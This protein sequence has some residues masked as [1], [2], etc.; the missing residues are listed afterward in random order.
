M[1]TKRPYELG[2]SAMFYRKRLMPHCLICNQPAEETHHI[3]P[4]AL[5]GADAYSNYVSLC[6]KCHADIEE[7]MQK[8]G[9]VELV[10]EL[11]QRK[12]K[13]EM[14]RWGWTC[15]GLGNQDVGVLLA[16]SSGIDVLGRYQEKQLRRR[17]YKR[18]RKNKL[19]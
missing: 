18:T 14:D 15:D 11:T 5:G 6:L 2:I 1:A 17:K 4:R 7:R 8:F 19:L 9:N 16:E 10:Y 12:I 13:A 3:W